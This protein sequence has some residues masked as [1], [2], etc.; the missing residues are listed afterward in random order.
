MYANAPIKGTHP[1]P[2]FSSHPISTMPTGCNKPWLICAVFFFAVIIVGLAIMVN[3]IPTASG[4]GKTEPDERISSHVLDISNGSPAKGVKLVSFKY[5]D[6]TQRWVELRETVTDANGRVNSVH[7][8]LPLDTGIYKITFHVQEYFD[9][10][11]QST[12]YP[13]IDVVFR[14]TDANLKLHVPLTL[15][16]FGYSTYKGQ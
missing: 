6:S 1:S 5:N 13:Q 16:N 4:P 15:S 2:T 11:N 14:V 10:L 12:F 7:P 9:N 8:G 3:A